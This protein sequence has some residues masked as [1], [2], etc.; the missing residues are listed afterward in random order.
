MDAD[1]LQL[2][3]YL[4][5]EIK[6][7]GVVTAIPDGDAQH[8]AATAF[9]RRELR[10]AGKVKDTLPQRRLRKSAME[11]C[12]EAI[13]VRADECHC[14][15]KA[16]AATQAIRGA[17]YKLCT[18]CLR[19]QEAYRLWIQVEQLITKR[20]QIQREYFSAVLNAQALLPVALSPV[21]KLPLTP[22]IAVK[23]LEVTKAMQEEENGN[24]ATRQSG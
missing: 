18:A 21:V 1:T 6:E 3:E 14:Y 13:K 23:A 19:A 7:A 20:L 8:R 22:A 12:L 5:S 17:S 15:P 11:A 9:I 24:S 2:V 10:Q 4:D 16:N